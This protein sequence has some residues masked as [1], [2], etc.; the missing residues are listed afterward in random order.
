MKHAL[1]IHPKLS[2]LAGGEFICLNVI[3]ACRKNGWKVTLLSDHVDLAK[4]EQIYGMGSLLQKIEWII[5]P[6]FKPVFSR[7]RALQAIRYGRQF[8]RFVQK[9][10]EDRGVQIIF[11]TQS[12]IFGLDNIPSYHFCYGDPK[13]LFVYPF[14]YY[15]KK[16]RW[17]YDLTIKAL[18]RLFIGAKPLP[19]AVFVNSKLVAA[20]LE[21]EGYHAFPYVPPIQP[22]FKPKPKKQQVVMVSRFDRGKRLEW[23]VE[24]ARQ[25]PE[26]SFILICRRD[27]EIER[28]F[29]PGYSE[30]I[31]SSLPPN[32]EFVGSP[33]RSVPRLVEE[34]KAYIYTGNEAG[35][36]L[37]MNEGIAAGC[38]PLAPKDTGN[39]EIIDTL[40]IGFTYSTPEQGAKRLRQAM[41]SDIDPQEIAK[42]ASRF[43]PEAFQEQ[44]QRDCKL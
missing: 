4:V 42:L 40:G 10:V 14:A 16:N 6:E 24:I 11:S 17:L 35:I 2:I 36:A 23:F 27:G 20:N 1:V 30:Q 8:K 19:T 32:I 44:L 18:V 22:I 33:V 43:S 21:E 12:S 31:L 38:I 28:L 9:I 13:D 39:A 29:A 37:V 34:S 26:Y 15:R 7:F 3:E 25:L 41:E 5:L